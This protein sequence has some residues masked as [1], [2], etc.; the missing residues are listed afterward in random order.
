V[1]SG[2]YMGSGHR[3]LLPRHATANGFQFKTRILRG[4][5]GATNGFPHEGRYFDSALLD[6]QHHGSSGWDFCLRLTTLHCV[7]ILGLIGLGWRY[8][9]RL[10]LT[11]CGLHNVSVTAGLRGRGRPRHAGLSNRTGCIS[12]IYFCGFQ[13]LAGM[14]RSSFFKISIFHFRLG[15]QELMLRRKGKIVGR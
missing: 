15:Q 3:R 9:H 7:W 5:D 11:E 4:F 12:R 10:V 8:W 13:G 6:V 14:I 1:R 2:G